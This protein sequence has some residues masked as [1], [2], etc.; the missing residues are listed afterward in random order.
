MSDFFLLRENF[1]LVFKHNTNVPGLSDSLKHLD[2]F[3]NI[4]DKLNVFF[5]KQKI[6]NTRSEMQDGSD[7]AELVGVKEVLSEIN[8]YA[9]KKLN[10]GKSV[11]YNIDFNKAVSGESDAH[12]GSHLVSS[13]GIE[14]KLKKLTCSLI[15]EVKLINKD[16]N[17][18]SIIKK[19]KSENVENIVFAFDVRH[20]S[21]IS[22]FCSDDSYFKKRM[23]KYAEEK[24][25]CDEKKIVVTFHLR[26]SDTVVYTT[27]KGELLSAWGNW[28]NPNKRSSDP[29]FLEDIKKA[30]Y[31]QYYFD[32]F[33]NLLSEIVAFIK[34]NYD[35]EIEVNFVSD[36]FKRGV[37]RLEEFKDKLGLDKKEIDYLRGVYKKEERLYIK[38][39]N[40]FKNNNNVIVNVYIGENKNNFLNTISAISRS[41][42]L[43]VGVGGFSKTVFEKMG[44][45]KKKVLLENLECFSFRDNENKDL[46]KFLKDIQ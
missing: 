28:R 21:I 14:E 12:I 17:L 44:Y 24:F 23:I 9:S 16:D 29:E 19:L 34:M 32:D 40:D 30:A 11:F 36:G 39:L 26:K 15:E 3:Y 38:R 33:Y 7:P 45:K 5:H 37:D 4:C 41:N 35:R 1:N 46:S 27:S 22:H 25:P 8:F 2:G 31:K 10:G 13:L 43:V 42:I 20:I 18:V 6:I